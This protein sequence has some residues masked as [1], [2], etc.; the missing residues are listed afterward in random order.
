MAPTPPYQNLA[1]HP[2]ASSS[3]SQAPNDVLATINEGVTSIDVTYK[4]VWT[5]CEPPP[6]GFISQ[7]PSVSRLAAEGIWTSREPPPPGFLSQTPSVSRLAAE[8]IWTSREPPPPGLLSQLPPL[9]GRAAEFLSTSSQNPFVGRREAGS[10]SIRFQEPPGSVRITGSAVA[11]SVRD[12]Y[13]SQHSGPSV[14]TPQPM[15]EEKLPCTAILK[16]GTLGALS[17]CIY[18]AITDNFSDF[19]AND[20]T[21]AHQNGYHDYGDVQMSTRKWLQGGWVSVEDDNGNDFLFVTVERDH[22]VVRV[23]RPNM[24]AKRVIEGGKT[25]LTHEEIMRLGLNEDASF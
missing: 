8:G 6:P 7:T 21:W 10:A 17:T 25:E 15:P 18:N 3:K 5:A 1:F 14:P 4:V 20:G 9:N 22:G 12:N 2:R 24:V 11:R 13:Q 23:W 16:R 19:S